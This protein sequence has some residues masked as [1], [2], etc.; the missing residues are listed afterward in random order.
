MGIGVGV[1]V[2][3]IAVIAAL[4]WGVY[5]ARRRAMRRRNELPA[6][7]NDKAQTEMEDNHL[8]ELGGK[9]LPVEL[10]GSDQTPVELPTA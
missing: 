4:A 3:G 1:G 5:G 6:E 10:N 2:A 8:R 7:S 9:E